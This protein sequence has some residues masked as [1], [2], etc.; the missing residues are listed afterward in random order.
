M[1]DVELTFNPA[2]FLGGIKKITDGVNTFS[3]KATTKFGDVGKI[4][5]SLTNRMPNFGKIKLPTFKESVNSVKEDFS[6][7]GKFFRNMFKSSKPSEDTEKESKKVKESVNGMSTFMVAKGMI[8]AQVLMGSF[9]KAFDFIK[10]GIPEVGRA[11]S[12]AGGIIQRNLFWPLRKELAPML[13]K[14]LDWVRDHREMFV[15]WG[16]ALVNMFRAITAVV[17]GFI[18]MFKAL[19]TPVAEKIKTLFGNTANGIS[20]I[21]NIVLFK[22]SSVVMFLQVAFMPLINSIGETLARMVEFVSSFFSG[23]ADGVAGIAGPFSDLITQLVALDKA[24]SLS[25]GSAGLLLSTL[26]VLGDFVGSTLY[27]IIAS[28]ASMV[29]GMTNSIQKFSNSIRSMKAM[30]SGDYNQVK[31][32]ADE[33]K[34]LDIQLATRNK[35]REI[36]LKNKWGGFVD[37]TKANFS[38]N[39]N[40]SSKQINATSKVNIEKMEIKVAPGEDPKKAGESFIEGMNKKNSQNFKNILLNEAGSMGY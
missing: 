29:D 11:M 22:I 24:L 7:L 32:I 14:M 35:Q 34:L 19:I 15:R 8:I 31:R 6:S 30:A 40:T 21:F 20:E 27:T 17:K 3:A 10:N 16:G 33:Q 28:A 26:K 37:R 9:R 23:F 18:A 1:D 25:D 2:S 38:P 4:V 39:S 36:D 12:I 13:Q 5:S